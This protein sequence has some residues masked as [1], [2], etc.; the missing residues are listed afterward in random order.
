MSNDWVKDIT[1][2]HTKFGVYDW[3]NDSTPEQRKQLL[4][5]R[6]RMLNEEFSETLNAYLQ[7]D[8]EEMVDGLIDLC[9]IAI[10]TLDIASV[11]ARRAWN[12]IY[13][14]NM[15]KQV[16]VKPGR[17]NPLGLPDLIKPSGWRPPR[18]D[19]NLGDLPTI[20]G[21]S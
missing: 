17:P 15:D 9:V 11:D 4:K 21:D 2:M 12:T 3:L 14:A 7:D 13:S 19:N 20:L 1:N 8:A 5:L 16:G 6:L 10:G 18:H